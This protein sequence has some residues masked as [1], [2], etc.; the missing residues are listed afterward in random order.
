MGGQPLTPDR[1]QPLVVLCGIGTLGDQLPLLALGVELRRRGIR[2][3]LLS[4]AGARS[5]AEAAG[6]GFISV[7]ADQGNNAVS[8]KEN[9]ETHVFPSYGPTRDYFQQQKQ[10]G[11][12]PVVVNQDSFSASNLAAEAL[13][14]P[15][16]RLYLSP[17]RIASL[18]NP[19]WPH[20]VHLNDEYR[21]SILRPLYE[22]RER[23]PYLLSKI[24]HYRQQWGLGPL[25]SMTQMD[26]SV[27]LRLG[28]FP[29]W[30]G[31]SG[32]DW[33][34]AFKHVGFLRP[35]D[36]PALSR[37]LG[38][39]LQG[40][41]RPIVF[42]PGTGSPDVKSWLAAAIHLCD[43]LERPGIVLS[44]HIPASGL[45]AG[46]QVFGSPFVQMDS[47][48]KKA[49]AIVHHG[50]IGTVAAAL[51][52][53]VPQ[54][55]CGAM[56]DQP[57]NGYR[58]QQL[59]VGEFFSGE[60]VQLTDLVTKLQGFKSTNTLHEQAKRVSLRFHAQDGARVAADYI[61]RLPSVLGMS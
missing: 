32:A 36:T 33:P 3:D 13:G 50:G 6:V 54:L 41:R 48:L 2:C 16:C 49:W 29:D 25:N 37:N 14:L 59:G 11:E 8:G 42:T 34:S 47:L 12:Q 30:F 22:R 23:S 4:N 45:I 9:M 20:C 24:G 1:R 56:Y 26:D 27:Q 60:E 5:A 52:A 55:I 61:E 46:T 57:D 18:V 35:T 28:L 19:A 44:R 15:V 39:F 7:T 40:K 43:V 10:L 38:E 53:G 17:D 21:E 51:R 58:V 31:P